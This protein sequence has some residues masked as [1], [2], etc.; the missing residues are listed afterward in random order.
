VYNGGSPGA[1]A[2]ATAD[3]TL[4]YTR[5]Q[6]RSYQRIVAYVNGVDGA[7]GTFFVQDKFVAADIDRIRAFWGCRRKPIGMTNE[8]VVTG[9]TAAGVMTYPNQPVVIQWGNSQATIQMVSPAP[10]LLRLVGGGNGINGAPAGPG[11][12]SY[13]DGANLDYYQ[14]AQSG[15][16]V[17]QYARIQG[18]WRLECETTKTAAN[19]Q[20]LF[21]ITVGDIGSTA[22]TYTDTQLLGIL[23]PKGRVV[24]VP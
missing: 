16:T 5:K 1:K 18:C 17:A 6:L 15:K 2:Q 8:T 21:A 24:L 9:S 11:Y 22:P 20:M 4:A 19:G 12:E 14:N 10:V 3:C 23:S 13:Y 7:H